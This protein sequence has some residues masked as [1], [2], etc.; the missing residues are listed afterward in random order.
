[1]YSNTLNY[2]G[3]TARTKKIGQEKISMDFI[4]DYLSAFQYAVGQSAPDLSSV[5]FYRTLLC[6]GQAIRQ[7]MGKVIF[8]IGD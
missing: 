8:Y 7:L 1:M 4:G 6:G 3:V 2:T 5:I